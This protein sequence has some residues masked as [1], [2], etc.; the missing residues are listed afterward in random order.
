MDMA[1]NADLA[2]ADLIEADLTPQPC[3]AS[4]QCM[5]SSRPICA[6]VC[7]A[8]GADPECTAAGLKPYC[9][10]A[11]G[12]CVTCLTNANCPT[13]A[14]P[15]CSAG[16]CRACLAHHECDSGACDR[17]TGLCIDSGGITYV[18]NHG[19][20]I[21]SCQVTYPTRDGTM[22]NP[23]CDIQEAIAATTGDTIVVRGHG[24]TFPYSGITITTGNS[25]WII[26][27]GKDASVPAVVS[28]AASALT[29]TG[30]TVELDGFVIGVGALFGASC[31]GTGTTVMSLVDTLVRGVLG[32]GVTTN[33]CDFTLDESRVMGAG[34]YGVSVNNGTYTMRNSVIADCYRAGVQ[35]QG[36]SGTFE[37]N[38]V[39]NNCNQPG[40][41]NEPGGVQCETSAYVISNS[42][43]H[44]NHQKNNNQIDKCGLAGIVVS[45]G[46]NTPAIP[47]S[48][49]AFG[50]DYHLLP[51]S[52][53]N[54]ACCVDKLATGPGFDIDGEVRPKGAQWDVGAD[55]VE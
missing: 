39:A 34:Q 5:D 20:S 23:Y 37:F 45:D 53:I 55:E 12:R 4:S 50:T 22:L 24:Q 11:S 44:G 36:S 26:G 49:V 16:D 54:A 19:S 30:G 52:S 38:T 13:P 46:N 1:A 6:G 10:V 17:S 48:S 18:D 8:C 27:P 51:M 7:R 29:V 31:A 35:L 25:L 40:S 33:S 21:V 41:P 15:V 47:S 9:E 2:S 3:T 43:V 42:I 28:G 14:K 32:N